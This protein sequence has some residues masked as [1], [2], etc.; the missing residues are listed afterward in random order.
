MVSAHANVPKG[1]AEG[2]LFAM[3]GD[4]GGFSFYMQNGKIIYGYN[5]V[6]DQIFRVESTGRMPEGDHIFG[7]EFTPTV[8]PDIA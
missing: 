2:V 3:G 1:G 4:D 5:Y 7:F 8:K 6:S